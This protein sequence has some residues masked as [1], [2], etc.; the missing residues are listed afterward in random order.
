MLFLTLPSP[1]LLV[2]ASVQDQRS[3]FVSTR[4]EGFPGSSTVA[5]DMSWLGSGGG[6]RYIEGYSF[7]QE[8]FRKR[9][10]DR[11]PCSE[12]EN[13]GDF[14]GCVQDHLQS[15]IPHCRLTAA[16]GRLQDEDKDVRPPCGASDP[17]ATDEVGALLSLSPSDIRAATG[18]RWPCATHRT[19]LRLDYAELLTNGTA[20]GETTGRGIGGDNLVVLAFAST[21]QSVLQVTEHL[22]HDLASFVA[23]LGSYLGL[24]VGVG[25]PDVLG[26]LSPLLN[27]GLAG[28]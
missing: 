5:P 20:A 28:T 13:V 17:G 27:K 9:S 1:D 14:G 7:R 18:C 12:E 15:R 10:T 4:G 23:D 8:E 2:R 6:S 22:S 16:S 26:Y 21:Q 19:S 3:F 24:L 25:L 11:N